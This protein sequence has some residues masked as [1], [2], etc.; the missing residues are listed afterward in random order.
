MINRVL[1]ENDND[2]SDCIHIGFP[3]SIWTRDTY[4]YK[5]KAPQEERGHETIDQYTSQ[6][7][8]RQDAGY[9]LQRQAWLVPYGAYG[10][11]QERYSAVSD[12]DR[13]GF[14]EEGYP[15]VDYE[16]ELQTT[17]ST[18]DRQATPNIVLV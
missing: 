5:Y 12:L 14:E 18:T 16:S 11:R 8:P 15:V 1:H 4:G 6:H 17:M 3:S 9:R 13:C 10:Y 2:Y 7:T